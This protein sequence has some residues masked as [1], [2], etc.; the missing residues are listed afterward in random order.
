MRNSNPK[1]QSFIKSSK[2]F[3]WKRK[4]FECKIIEHEEKIIPLEEMLGKKQNEKETG[5]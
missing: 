3:N 5:K 2:P 1:R 4:F